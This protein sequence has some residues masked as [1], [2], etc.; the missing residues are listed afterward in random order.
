MAYKYID[1]HTHVNLNAFAEDWEEAIERAQSEEV[2]I[3]NVGTQKDTS[4]SAVRLAE[5]FPDGVYATIGIHP[6]HATKSYHDREELGPEQKG[7]NSRGER[8]DISYYRELGEN[9]KVVAI[10]ECGFDYY[11]VEKDTKEKQEE[12]FI[13]Q[14]ELANELGKP[15]MLHVRPSI[16]TMDAYEDALRVVKQYA[17][18]RGNVH[19]FAGNLETAKKFWDSGYT[20]SFTGVITFTHD[21]DEVV[22]NAPL[23]MIHGETDAPYVAPV[24][25]RGKRNEPLHVREVYKKI[26]D[27]RREDEEHI[28]IQLVENAHRVFGI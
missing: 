26:A 24:P 17:K 14:I 28:R 3:I 15:L 6:I 9:E 1:V 10:G 25:Y 12:T 23:D 13:K 16:G 27:I 4:E 7:F 11:R 20:T 5:A 19:F 8:Y 2:A 21:Y 18:V 22:K